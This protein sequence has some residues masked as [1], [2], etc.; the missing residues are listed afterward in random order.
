MLKPKRPSTMTLNKSKLV[1]AREKGVDE[2]L[3]R[4]VMHENLCS[5]PYKRRE[6]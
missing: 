1:I 3:I 6:G 2:K 5:V 4:L